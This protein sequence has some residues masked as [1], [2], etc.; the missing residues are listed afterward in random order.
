[1][2]EEGDCAS[3]GGNATDSTLPEP[4]CLFCRSTPQ[5]ARGIL[6]AGV[7]EKGSRRELSVN[8]SKSEGT[9]RES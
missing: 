9:G 1:M 2:K 7:G 6:F 3:A 4:E 5:A 8:E